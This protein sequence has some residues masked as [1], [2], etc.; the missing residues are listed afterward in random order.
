MYCC[1]EETPLGLSE[2]RLFPKIEHT[3]TT[4][5]DVNAS[6]HT[7]LHLIIT[8]LQ[9]PF[10]ISVPCRFLHHTPLFWQNAQKKG[11]GDLLH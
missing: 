7:D 3:R 6:S 8:F 9:R 5:A 10:V 2:Q 11:N 4:D 1:L